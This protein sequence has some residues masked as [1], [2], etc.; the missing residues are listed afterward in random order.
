MVKPFETRPAT[1]GNK[2]GGFCILCGKPAT[3]E[4][5]FRLE[6]AIVI[7]RYC[8]TCLP[9]ANYYPVV[10]SPWIKLTRLY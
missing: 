5:L 3:T 7:Q 10:A 1:A 9:K 6:G 8:D 4:A 2:G